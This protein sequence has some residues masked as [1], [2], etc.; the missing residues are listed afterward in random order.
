[1]FFDAQEI[2]NKFSRPATPIMSGIIDL[3][4]SFFFIYY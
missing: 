2:I 4:H 3:H 1:M